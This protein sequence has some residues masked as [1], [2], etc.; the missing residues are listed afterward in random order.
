MKILG[1]PVQSFDLIRRL[2]ITTHALDVSGLHL[3]KQSTYSG[4]KKVTQEIYEELL[5]TNLLHL[6]VAVRTNIYQGNLNPSDQDVLPVG[7][8]EVTSSNGKE[9]T[10]T[11]T[12]KDI[13]D[14]IIHAQEIVKHLEDLG[15]SGKTVMMITG[16]HRGEK[17]RLDLSVEL[18]CEAVLNLLDATE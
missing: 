12:I 17:W 3:F 9:K 7:F 10:V 6:A 11:F 5:F 8:L 15:G 14:K 2:A 13:C 4:G 16:S 18:F 1:N